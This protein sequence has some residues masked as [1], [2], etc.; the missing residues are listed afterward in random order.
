MVVKRTL[1]TLRPDSTNEI[2]QMRSRWIAVHVAFYATV[3]VIATMASH[4]VSPGTWQ[5]SVATVG[6]AATALMTIPG[7]VELVSRRV[8]G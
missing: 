4:S 8:V 6:A 5:W 3:A 2:R 1:T 7:A